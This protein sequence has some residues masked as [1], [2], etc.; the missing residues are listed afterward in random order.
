MSKGITLS[1]EH[2]LNPTI[3]KCFYCGKD[4]GI[5]LMGKIT[6]KKT[7]KNAWGNSCTVLEDQKAPRYAVVDY[8]PC[9]ECRALFEQGILILEVVDH[10]IDE[11]QPPIHPKNPN[12]FPTGRHVILRRES[13][14]NEEVLKAGRS[15]MWKNEFETMFGGQLNDSH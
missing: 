1:P 8:E 2:G 13:V 10:P 6:A 4:T 3:T 14:D 15:V 12:C 5:A 7:T 11:G 9:D